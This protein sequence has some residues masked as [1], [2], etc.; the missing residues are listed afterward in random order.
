MDAWSQSGLKWPML[1]QG[2]PEMEELQHW[3]F[4]PSSLAYL[5]KEGIEFS[6]TSNK[7][8]NPEAEF[9]DRVRTAVKRG[10]DPRIALKALTTIPANYLGMESRLGEL[11]E[12]VIA[13]IVVTEG[14][15]FHQGKKRR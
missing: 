6:L 13:N 3:E 8:E 7:T 10:L 5:A 9:W 15:I 2:F 11:R 1:V 14:D 4:A 12:G